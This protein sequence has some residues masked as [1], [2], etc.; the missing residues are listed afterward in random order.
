MTE[1]CCV[2]MVS[3]IYRGQFGETRI[4]SILVK[5]KILVTEMNIIINDVWEYDLI[6]IV[7]VIMAENTEV[8][9]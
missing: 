9:L 5:K 3:Q 4:I 7:K 8:H 6:N 2:R 1:L